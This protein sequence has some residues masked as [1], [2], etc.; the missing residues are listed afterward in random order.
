M[1][2][3]AFTDPPEVEPDM[4]STLTG[5]PPPPR[6]Q[7][8]A[9]PP[10]PA[11]PAPSAH[12]RSAKAAPSTTS[13]R[14]DDAPPRHPH[15]PGAGNRTARRI[16]LYV[17]SEFLGRVRRKSLELQMQGQSGDITSMFLAAYDA[18]YGKD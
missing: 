2:R 16:G 4:L 1:A 3:Q 18:Y 6:P 8:A 15:A 14:H 12:P 5:A 11:S 9:P 10:V 13:P 17:T 7:P